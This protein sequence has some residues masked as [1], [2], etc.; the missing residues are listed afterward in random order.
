MKQGAK[1]TKSYSIKE[2]KDGHSWRLLGNV[3]I[4]DSWQEAKKI[5]TE[6]LIEWLDEE[7]SDSGIDAH[8]KVGAEYRAGHYMDTFRYDVT[9]WTIKKVN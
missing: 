3:I 9:T 7:N 5:F 6:W 1:M 4:A 8:E 2:R